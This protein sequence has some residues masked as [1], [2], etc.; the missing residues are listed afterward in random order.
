MI[1]QNAT[2][3]R[4]VSRSHHDR[5]RPLDDRPVLVLL[6]LF[7]SFVIIVFTFTRAHLVAD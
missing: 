6:L 4:C 7:S 5:Q 1:L 2:T 3:A